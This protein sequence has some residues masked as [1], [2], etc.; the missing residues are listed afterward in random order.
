MKIIRVNKDRLVET[1]KK[2]LVAHNERHA[3]ALEGWKKECKKTAKDIIK[4]MDNTDPKQ[5]QIPLKPVDMQMSYQ[6]AISKCLWEVDDE[7]ELDESE[8]QNY[9]L[10]K[11]GWK[12]QWEFS[13]SIYLSR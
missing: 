7:I 2:N 1:L 11:W 10:D 8:V 6:E 4:D 5:P 13:N 3:L 9:I 12:N